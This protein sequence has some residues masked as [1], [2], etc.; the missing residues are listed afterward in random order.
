[1]SSTLRGP[2]SEANIRLRP[3]T[4]KAGIAGVLPYP[5]PTSVA[6][7]KTMCANRRTD[8]GP[9]IAIRSLLQRSGHRFRKDLPIQAG[10]KK[11]RPDIVFTRQ[12]VAVFIDGC[13]WHRCPDHGLIPIR[14]NSY[15]RPKLEGNAQRDKLVNQSLQ[16]AGWRVLRFWE[17]T[18]A[19]RMLQSIA[20]CLRLQTPT[21]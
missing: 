5:Q 7:Q 20:E 18:P 9:E 19:E 12:R 4:L 15:W 8:T 2:A 21:V 16:S 17:H 1:M 11:V 6:A 10:G 14:N 13:F 3:P